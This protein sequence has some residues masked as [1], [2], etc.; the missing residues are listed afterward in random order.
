M[1]FV[2]GGFWERQV[3]ITPNFHLCISNAGCLL[4]LGT[5]ASCN[6]H[7]GQLTGTE[8]SGESSERPAAHPVSRR[9][10]AAGMFAQLEQ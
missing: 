10:Q 8:P 2:P 9:L 3:A 6:H 1:S 5:T 4:V 7:L